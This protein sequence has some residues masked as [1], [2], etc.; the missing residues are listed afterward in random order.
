MSGL[1]FGVICGALNCLVFLQKPVRHCDAWAAA[2]LGKSSASCG[3]AGGL[4]DVTVP[5]AFV[6]WAGGLP[7]VLIARSLLQ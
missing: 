7:D 6:E 3:Y 2:L 5:G 1:K 4:R